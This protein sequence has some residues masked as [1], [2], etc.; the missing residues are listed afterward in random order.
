MVPPVCHTVPARPEELPRRC[1]LMQAMVK[2]AGAALSV[3]QPWKSEM[4]K[5]PPCLGPG[6]RAA[7]P[8]R[9]CI[10]HVF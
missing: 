1:D 10:N 6:M 9:P 4:R 2:R 5:V 8:G 3:K 7:W